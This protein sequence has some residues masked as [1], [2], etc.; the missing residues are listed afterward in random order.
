MTKTDRSLW[1]EINEYLTACDIDGDDLEKDDIRNILAKHIPQTPRL[2]TTVPDDGV[3]KVAK[4]EIAALK[5]AGYISP[6]GYAALDEI[7]SRHPH[8]AQ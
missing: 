5:K 1:R 6:Y 4:A 2:K 7:L 3:I 8:P